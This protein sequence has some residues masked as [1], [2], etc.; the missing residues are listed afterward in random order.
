MPKEEKSGD[1]SGCAVLSDVPGITRQLWDMAESCF[2]SQF[3]AL[4]RVQFPLPTSQA[5]PGEGI[6]RL[7]S[8][9]GARIDTQQPPLPQ[10]C[11][12]RLLHLR[13]CSILKKMVAG[14]F[15]TYFRPGSRLLGFPCRQQ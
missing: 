5:G 11:Q 13:C 12:D 6:L 3:F 9:P 2:P 10:R 1:A 7:S 4:P 15:Y 8:S 14:S